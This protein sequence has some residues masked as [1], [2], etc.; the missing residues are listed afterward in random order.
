MNG[1]IHARLTSTNRICFRLA[2]VGPTISISCVVH[3]LEYSGNLDI[4][5]FPCLGL[6]LLNLGVTDYASREASVVPR[7]VC[8]TQWD[9]GEK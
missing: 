4:E 7:E 2:S 6:P 5:S 1:S 8:M 9:L 3:R